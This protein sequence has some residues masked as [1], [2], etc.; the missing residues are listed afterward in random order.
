[1]KKS[2]AVKNFIEKLAVL[3]LLFLRKNKSVLFYKNIPELVV[4]IFLS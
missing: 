3:D 4:S 1:M 2:E